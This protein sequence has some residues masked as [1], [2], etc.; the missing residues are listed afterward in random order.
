MLY[1]ENAFRWS[2]F[3]HNLKMNGSSRKK[4]R[5]KKLLELLS[6]VLVTFGCAFDVSNSIAFYTL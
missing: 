4:Q 6:C 3:H 1:F 2:F 5:K